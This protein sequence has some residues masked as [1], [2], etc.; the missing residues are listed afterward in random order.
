MFVLTLFVLKPKASL[1]Y[2]GSLVVATLGD[3]V[4]LVSKF[5]TAFNT[6]LNPAKEESQSDLNTTRR[7]LVFVFIV[8]KPD[9]SA[10]NLRGLSDETSNKLR[11]SNS[12]S[13]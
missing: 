13:I 5:I 12:V 9:T 1:V 6:A 4:S 10:I 2:S 3:V 8:P 7:L 11:L